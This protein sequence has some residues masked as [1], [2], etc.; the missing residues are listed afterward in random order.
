MKTRIL[1]LVI[2]AT[3]L[4]MLGTT[5]AIPITPASDVKAAIPA[6]PE[7]KARRIEG[8]WHPAK[9]PDGRY[10]A[11]RPGLSD[12]RSRGNTC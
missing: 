5:G 8:T 4:L 11:D 7:S 6:M 1:N 2:V 9:L 10:S 12:I 3:L